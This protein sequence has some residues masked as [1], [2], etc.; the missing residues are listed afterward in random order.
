MEIDTEIQPSNNVMAAAEGKSVN[1]ESIKNPDFST[2][3]DLNDEA[4]K[5]FIDKREGVS[6]IYKAFDCCR[7]SWHLKVDIDP[8]SKGVSLWVIEREEPLEE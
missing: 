8:I 6:I 7:R 5:V 1:T 4:L 3:I 2:V